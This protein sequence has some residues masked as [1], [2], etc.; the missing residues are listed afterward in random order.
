MFTV[1]LCHF[2]VVH[3]EQKPQHCAQV[4][5]NPLQS[6]LTPCNTNKVSKMY[7]MTA[8]ITLTS[9]KATEL[10]TLLERVPS[11]I[12]NHPS[13][14]DVQK[15]CTIM[16]NT[17]QSLQSHATS[18]ET[19]TQFSMQPFHVHGQPLQSMEQSQNTISKESMQDHIHRRKMSRVLLSMHLCIHLRL[20]PN[21]SFVEDPVECRS[22]RE[23]G[24]TPCLNWNNQKTQSPKNACRTISTEERC[25]QHCFKC[26]SAST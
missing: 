5:A 2:H 25:R 17:N 26:I 22:H 1:N 13:S 14:A 23:R 19:R 6:P 15:F 8:I 18:T 20:R 16:L 3:Q 24:K 9:T 21:D 12:F 11:I 4:L 7:I 10:H